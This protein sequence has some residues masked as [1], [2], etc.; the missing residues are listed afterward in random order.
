VVVREGEVCTAPLLLHC[1]RSGA[2]L[3]HCKGG[4]GEGGAGAGSALVQ[5]LESESFF[6]GVCE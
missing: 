4:A 2:Q 5:M 1:C 6:V 3:R